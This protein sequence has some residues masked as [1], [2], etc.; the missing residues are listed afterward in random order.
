MSNAHLPPVPPENRSPHG[1]SNAGK[2]EI[3]PKEAK[4]NATQRDPAQQGRQ[5]IGRAVLKLFH[6]MRVEARRV[7]VEEF[8]HI[9]GGRAV[10]GR[11]LAQ[12][13][14]Q[15]AGL[16]RQLRRQARGGIRN[17]ANRH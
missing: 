8:A 10:R 12:R 4:A 15:E 13:G 2:G 14:Q 17:D 16:F 3:S 11:V 9:G 6:Q 7:A 5:G 1:G